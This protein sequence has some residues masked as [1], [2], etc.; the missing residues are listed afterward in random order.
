ML[1]PT[2]SLYSA[3]APD[4]IYDVTCTVHRAHTGVARALVL[5]VLTYQL[6]IFLSSVALLNRV[7]G[8]T[9]RSQSAR[10]PHTT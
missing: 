9:A 10:V 8:V 2:D 5:V 7:L 1:N 6:L 3:T 4:C